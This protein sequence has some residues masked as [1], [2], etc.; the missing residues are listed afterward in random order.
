MADA[1]LNRRVTVRLGYSPAFVQVEIVGLN[2][3]MELEALRLSGLPKAA[4][5]LLSGTPTLPVGHREL[6]LETLLDLP[7]LAAGA[8]HL[9]DVAVPGAR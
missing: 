8:V 4:P 2:G 5:A 7:S 1:S 3:Q 9:V 6:A